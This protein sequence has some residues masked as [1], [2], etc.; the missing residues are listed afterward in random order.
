MS[1]N[2]VFSNIYHVA[3]SPH[4]LFFSP[5]QI[6]QARYQCLFPLQL[7]GITLPRL[8]TDSA[9]PSFFIRSQVDVVGS[10]EQFPIAPGLFLALMGEE[11][12]IHLHTPE[13]GPKIQHL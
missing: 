5:P 8:Y 10:P 2:F 6:Q 11:I 1:F 9:G 7:F 13:N 4:F 12:C 3:F